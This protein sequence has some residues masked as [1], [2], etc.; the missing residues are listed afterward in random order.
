METR[1]IKLHVVTSSGKPLSGIEVKVVVDNRTF[2]TRTDKYGYVVIN[3]GLI[4]PKVI[5][6]E[7]SIHNTTIT[8]EVIASTTEI[9]VIVNLHNLTIIVTGASGQAIPGAE[10]EIRDESGRLVDYGVTNDMGLI[11]FTNLPEGKYI[12]I[13]KVGTSTYTRELYLGKSVK[14]V[15]STDVIAFTSTPWGKISI[16]LTSL[17]IAIAVI[18]PTI[19]AVR[20]LIKHRKESEEYDVSVV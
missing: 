14:E 1:P 6:I 10:V 16:T 15:I 17:L 7:L 4:R 12:I 2:I 19:I 20:Y 5:K 18:T 8:K 11:T 3:P 9:N 13:V